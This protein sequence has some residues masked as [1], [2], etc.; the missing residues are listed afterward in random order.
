MIGGTGS[1]LFRSEAIK[2]STQ[3]MTERKPVQRRAVAFLEASMGQL[4][5]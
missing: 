2:A 4:T 3:T 1:I 5:S